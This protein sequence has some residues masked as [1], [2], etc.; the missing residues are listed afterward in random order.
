MEQWCIRL[1]GSQLP[2][3]ADIGGKAHG[4]ARMRRLGLPVPDA[5][6]LPTSIGRSYHARGVSLP[7]EAW[8]AVRRSIADLEAA[9][10]RTFGRGPSPLLVSVRSGAAQSMPGMMD[11]VLNLGM[12]DTVQEALA[13]ESGNAQF[14]QD[15]HRRFIESYARHVLHAEVDFEEPRPPA[16]LRRTVEQACGVSVPEDP[17]EQ[18]QG[19]I[20]AV[21]GSWN[22]PRCI[23]YR[24]H[25]RISDEGGT[26]VTVQAMVF[27]NLDE[28]SGTGVFFTRDPA[29]GDPQPYGDFL[30]RGQGE[31][32]V[33]GTVTPLHLDSLKNRLPDVYDE[34]INAGALLERDAKDS[35]DIEFTIE[36]GRL[37]IL[38]TRNAKRSPAAAIRIAVEL[39]NEGL[40]SREEALQRVGADQVEAVLKATID[41]EVLDRAVVV[42]TG[43][44]ACPGIASGLAVGDADAAIDRE[45]E[46]EAAILVRHSTSPEDVHGMI[47]AVGVCTEVGG[48]T[49]HAAV[50]SRELGR[51]CIVG[52]GEG[53]LQ[54]LIGQVITMDGDTG[55]IYAGELPAVQPTVN[56]HPGLAE[57]VSWAAEHSGV[58]NSA[59][60]L[61]KLATDQRSGA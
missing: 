8:E 55:W 32:V 9:Q 4:I 35:Q 31:D 41:P 34:L 45:S 11:T 57:L 28:N 26:A 23:A 14:A 49:S 30:P 1:D 40:I 56:D 42:A 27:G 36:R 12:N 25:H 52:C 39:E 3:R 33:S 19:A 7:D 46:G 38:Q 58:L 6:V 44:S 17:F 5:F 18:L 21:F 53:A 22:S 51:P 20:G 15:T 61:R 43:E 13:A 2:S 54:G 29:T 16:E 24:R 50:V 47:A 48:K 60:P 59:H 10:G 37:Y